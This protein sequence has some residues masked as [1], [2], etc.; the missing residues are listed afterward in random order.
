[1]KKIFFAVIASVAAL[2]SISIAHAEG[3]YVGA[4][5]TTGRYKF[6]V[7]N[8][9]S[10]GDRSSYKVGG[11]LFAGYEFDKTWAVEGGF[12]NF[13]S[14][15]YSYVQNGVNGK[16]DAKTR[17]YYIAGKATMPINEQFGVFG[18]LGVARNRDSISGTGAA[19]GL[20][21]TDNK[22]GLYASVGAQYA[23]NKNISLSAELEHFGKSAS[24]GHKAT[25][26]ALGA[27]Y[28]F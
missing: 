9:S 4:G 14:K 23:L 3:A 27:R 18:K 2:S 17:G 22:T 19:S 12:A 1:M 28:N 16:I 20:S 24:Y 13:G 25:A 15:S 11:K 8:V 26:L 6:D 7:P 5:V 21:K 10:G